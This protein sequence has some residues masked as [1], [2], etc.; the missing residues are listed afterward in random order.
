MLLF[1]RG[2]SAITDTMGL[3]AKNLARSIKWHISPIIRPPPSFGEWSQDSTGTDPAFIRKTINLGPLIAASIFLALTA[4]GA[5]R[6]LNPTWKKAFAS[7]RARRIASSSS[8]LRPSGFSTRTDLPADKASTVRRAWLLWRLATSTALMLGFSNMSFSSQHALVKPNLFWLK[9]AD[10]PLLV[11]SVW[12][13]APGTFEISGSNVLRAKLPP[14]ITPSTHASF[15]TEVWTCWE[16]L[17]GTC[18]VSR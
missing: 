11:T 12:S 7:F 9:S 1:E 13:M 18:L 4:S 6:R 16:G 10:A 2:E 8:L 17:L 14:P 3:L 15:F 5:N